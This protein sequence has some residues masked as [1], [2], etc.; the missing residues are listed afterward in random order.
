MPRRAILNLKSRVRDA[1]S[2]GTLGTLV[3]RIAKAVDRPSSKKLAQLTLDSIGDAVIGTDPEGRVTYLN[4]VAESL[5]GWARE[6]AVGYPITEV[7][8]MVHATTRESIVNP[9]MEAM[10]EDR[11]VPLAP[12]AVLLRRD[13]SET[14]IE[15]CA[16]PIHGA[17]GAVIG[18]VIVLHDVTA[19]RT[20]SLKLSYGAQYDS[21]TDLPNRTL[22]R[23]RLRQAISHAHRGRQKLAVLFLDLDRF[24]EIND[25]LGHAVGDRL[26]QSVAQRLISCVRGSD[27]VCRRSGDEFL[28]LLAQVAHAR[29]AGLAAEKILASLAE[30][31][32]IDGTE[33]RATASIGIGI[34]PD[35]GAEADSLMKSAD[36][37]MYAAKDDGRSIFHYFKPEMNAR[38]AERQSIEAGLRAGLERDEFKL[39]YQPKINL[40]TGAI[41]GVEALL[42]WASPERGLL[43]PVQ[44]L[45]IAEESGLIVPIGRWALREAC[46]QNCAWQD[47][48][49]PPVR[50]SVNVSAVDLRS[51]GFVDAVRAVLDETGLGSRFLELDLTESLLLADSSA[52]LAVNH[53]LKTCGVQLALDNFGNGYSSLGH[54]KRF[55]IDSLKINPSFVHGATLN[56]DDA[57]LVGAV[58][59]MGRSLGL[60]VVAEGIETREQLAFLR[61]QGCPEGQGHYFS[62]PVNADLF[63]EQLRMGLSPIGPS[64]RGGRARAAF[65][66]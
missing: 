12:N 24:K 35:D 28:I 40:S 8:R 21:L 20:L 5:V 15:D 33:L 14:A 43:S 57:G 22:F 39:L 7:L 34:Y 1:L 63:S 62:E 16:S 25:S 23:D 50:V 54:L 60:R 52:A 42:R 45:T 31:H 51:E 27:T 65:A 30:A 19:A 9:L 13:G 17:D 38:V 49:L 41:V 46:R 11:S 6:E 37:A 32:V 29:D 53:A 36:I 44:F 56:A 55:R 26:L 18:G 64:V 10:K 66:G 4:D 3:E 59:G 48:G 2:G 58:I 47:A 61:E